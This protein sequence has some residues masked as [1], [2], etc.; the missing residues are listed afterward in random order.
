MQSY[1]DVTLQ[2]ELGRKKNTN[3]E[4]DMFSIIIRPTRFN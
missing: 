3:N 2:V 4:I 1:A